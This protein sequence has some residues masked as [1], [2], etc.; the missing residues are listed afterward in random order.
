MA[1]YASIVF[2]RNALN[3]VLST[4]NRYVPQTQV[5]IKYMCS[6]NP[7]SASETV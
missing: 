5:V 2:A 3:S 6:L 7:A 4:F 1:I